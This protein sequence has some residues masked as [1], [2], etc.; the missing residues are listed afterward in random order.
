VS[1]NFF[2]E[3]VVVLEAVDHQRVDDVHIVVHVLDRIV[4]V[5]PKNDEHEQNLVHVQEHDQNQDQDLVA[6]DRFFI[7]KQKKEL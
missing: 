5:D 4:Q 7:K 3:V 1:S 6:V 2:L